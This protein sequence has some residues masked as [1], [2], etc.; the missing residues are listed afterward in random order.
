MGRKPDPC[1]KCG[2]DTRREAEDI[3]GAHQLVCRCGH[4]CI[5]CT[6][7]IYAGLI[8]ECPKC[9]REFNYK[10]VNVADQSADSPESDKTPP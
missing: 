3:M 1:R 6:E 7:S 2:S 8:T 10:R 5:A 9:G 4:F